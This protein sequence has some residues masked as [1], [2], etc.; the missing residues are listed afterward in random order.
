MGM[1]AAAPARTG[2]S[3]VEYEAAY[4]EH[5]QATVRY[6]SK[7]SAV[8]AEDV[9]QCAWLRAWRYRSTFSGLCS[10]WTWVI[11]IARNELAEDRRGNTRNYRNRRETLDLT[12]I[13]DAGRRAK[14]LEDSA[15]VD[16]ILGRI[17]PIYAT[18]LW[19]RFAEGREGTEIFGGNRTTA[20]RRV[21]RALEAARG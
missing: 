8:D 19:Q 16:K 1:S 12:F 7:C 20:W 15:E 14:N 5:F 21:T 10:V 13:H 6:L 3:E 9:A 17:D 11:A 18:L 2:L 4:R